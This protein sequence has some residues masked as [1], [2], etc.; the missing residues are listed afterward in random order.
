MDIIAIEYAAQAARIRQEA[1]AAAAEQQRLLREARRA[2]RPAE[3][4]AG[5]RRRHATGPSV[6][7]L[8][9]HGRLAR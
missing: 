5:D 4:P 8:W 6:A 9:L 1:A 2:G 7:W 3:T